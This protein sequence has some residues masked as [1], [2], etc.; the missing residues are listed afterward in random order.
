MAWQA[1]CGQFLATN[2]AAL[3]KDPGAIA[4]DPL[5]EILRYNLSTRYFLMILTPWFI[6]KGI[7]AK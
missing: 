3:P 2:G 5:P 1:E 7:S 6:L 4:A